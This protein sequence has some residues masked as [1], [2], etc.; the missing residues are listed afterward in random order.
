VHAEAFGGYKLSGF[1][2]RDNAFSAMINIPKPKRSGS[3]LAT[4]VINQMEP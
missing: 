1:G 3:T 2:G 4:I